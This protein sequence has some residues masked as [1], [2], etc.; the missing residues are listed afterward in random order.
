MQ[1]SSTRLASEGGAAN[2]RETRKCHSVYC[3]WYVP[4][5]DSAVEDGSDLAH[6]V[7]E[8]G[9]LFG[10][11]GLHAVGES[12]VRFVMHFNE[13]AIR[14]DGHRRARERQNLVAFARAMTR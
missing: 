14:A 9:E 6:F 3:L 2:R 8:F 12:F 10:Q 13:Q 11:N 4:S 1:R 7:G 5:I